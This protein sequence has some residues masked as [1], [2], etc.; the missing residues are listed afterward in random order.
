[1]SIPP[2]SGSDRN[3][4]PWWDV[5]RKRPEVSENFGRS[6]T[7]GRFPREGLLERSLLL[8][9]DAEVRVGQPGPE[10]RRRRLGRSRGRSRR[11]IDRRDRVDRRAEL[12]SDPL[13]AAERE[14]DSARRDRGGR[15]YRLGAEGGREDERADARLRAGSEVG[16]ELEPVRQARLDEGAVSQPTRDRVELATGLRDQDQPS[17]AVRPDP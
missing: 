11:R 5:A 13:E 2:R 3:P 10:A 8:D 12:R 7:A 16:R 9:G 14:P 15:G 6:G 17:P 1:M 4:T